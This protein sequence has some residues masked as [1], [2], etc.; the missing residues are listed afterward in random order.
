MA[1]SPKADAASGRQGARAI[2]RGRFSS[3]VSADASLRAVGGLGAA[4]S[5]VYGAGLRAGDILG[6]GLSAGARGATWEN[7]FT[8]GG[9]LSLTLNRSW[10]KGRASSGV[11]FGR[12]RA[13]MKSGA[14]RLDS[15]WSSLQLSANPLRRVT[16]SLFFD[17]QTG[18]GARASQ[19][20]LDVSYR[21]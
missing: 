15:G 2:A 20:V 17:R 18:G 8:S 13:E 14:R 12:R 6:T 16:A 9:S 7:D 10:L 4:G 5:P 21:L 1:Q 11:E 19:A 3:P